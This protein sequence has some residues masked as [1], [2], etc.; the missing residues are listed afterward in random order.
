MQLEQ[1]IHNAT[2]EI[3]RDVGVVIH[4]EEALGIFQRNGFKTEGNVVFFTEEQVWEWIK[5]APES[6]TLYGRDSKYDTV[7]GGWNVNTAAS[8]GCPFILDRDGTVRRGSMKDFITLEKVVH[9]LDEFEISGGPLLS[10]E[11]VPAETANVDMFYASFLLSGKPMLIAPGSVEAT[12]AI[13][14]AGCEIFGGKEEFAAKPRM[15]MLINTNSPLSLADNMAENLM[16]LA[17]YGQPVILCPASMMGATSSIDVA[18]TLASNSAETLAGIVL[19]EMVNP[20]T[21][22]CYGIQST[23]MD[24][25]TVGFACAAPEGALMQGFGANMARFYGLPSRGGGCQ[26]DSPIINVQAGYESMLTYYSSYTHGINM[27]LVAGGVLDSCNIV[28]LDMLLIDGEIIKMVKTACKPFEV[29]E[30]TLHLDEIKENGHNAGF[31]NC[32]STLENFHDL[33]SP[34][35][36]TRGSKMTEAEFCKTLDARLENVLS[37]ADNTAPV[38]SEELKGRIKQVLHDN[39]GISIDQLS[40]YEQY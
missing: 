28:S 1:A 25:K 13:M 3:M 7:V 29:N 22:V 21:P 36:G 10:P 32:D 39:C 37:K 12:T 31:L 34:S 19:A 16:I 4:N 18:G 38:T 33:Y 9:G 8:Y 26:S 17:R 23:A 2:M 35:I 5:K 6:F 30:D 24:M 15:I 27:V 11:D 40:R 14:E 20:G